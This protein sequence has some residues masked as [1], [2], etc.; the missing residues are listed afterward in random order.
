[1][2]LFLK[3]RQFRQLRQ[4]TKNSDDNQGE[5]FL[6]WQ[7]DWLLKHFLTELS[8]KPD[9]SVHYCFSVNVQLDASTSLDFSLLIY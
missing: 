5:M 6:C 3:P 1:V 9:K 4:R 2:G 8:D 7:V